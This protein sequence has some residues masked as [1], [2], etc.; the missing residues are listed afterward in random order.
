[1]QKIY[2]QYLSQEEKNLSH[3]IYLCMTLESLRSRAGQLSAHPPT[4]SSLHSQFS[5]REQNS[6][7]N[8]SCIN[9]YVISSINQWATDFTNKMMF[10]AEH[11]FLRQELLKNNKSGVYSFLHFLLARS[12]NHLYKFEDF[13]NILHSRSLIE[14]GLISSQ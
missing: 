4:L 13:R 2:T 5:G 9:W 11:L 3:E 14:G 6:C 7:E 10:W 1:M 8:I 12:A